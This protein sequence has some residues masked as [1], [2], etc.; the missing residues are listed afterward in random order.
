MAGRNTPAPLLDEANAAFIQGG[1]AIYAASRTAD[2]IPV[3][4][5]VLGCRVSKDR[6]SLTVL[7]YNGGSRDLLEGVRV[8]KEIAVVFTQPSTHQT[9]QLKG[10][11][12]VVA[13]AE[14]QDIE[15]AILHTDELVADVCPMGYPEPLVRA[16]VWFDPDDVRVVTFTPIAAFLQTPGPRAGEPLQGGNTC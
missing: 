11:D 15:S 6:R 4:S 13:A 7:F 8:S 16:V 2:N 9:I 3:T 5:R 14:K 10:T 1:V 12:A